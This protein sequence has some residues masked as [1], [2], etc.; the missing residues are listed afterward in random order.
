MMQ[1]S[2][3]KVATRRPTAQNAA[4][5]LLAYVLSNIHT[6]LSISATNKHL[7]LLVELGHEIR[8]SS[9]PRHATFP[10]AATALDVPLHGD[11]CQHRAGTT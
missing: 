3:A 6:S 7:A 9:I 2:V 4:Y 5:A 10:R 11:A 8:E 1:I